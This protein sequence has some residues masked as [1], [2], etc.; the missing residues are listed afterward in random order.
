VNVSD[1]FFELLVVISW[2]ILWVNLGWR[3][4]YSE[5]NVERS[6]GTHFTRSKWF[7]YS[8]HLLLTGKMKLHKLSMPV[9][10][11][12]V[13]YCEEELDFGLHHGHFH[14]CYFVSC[15]VCLVLF[16]SLVIGIPNKI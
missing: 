16:G 10:F 6:V 3:Q 4:R 8:Q 7:L 12:H 15:L 11:S 1:V 2:L 5:T 13:L 14:V 9:I